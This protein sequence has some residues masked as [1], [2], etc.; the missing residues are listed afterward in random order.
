MITEQEV[1]QEKELTFRDYILKGKA[2]FREALRYWYIPVL[3]GLLGIAYQYYRYSKIVAKYPATITFIIDEDESGSS[4]LSGMLSQFGLSGV[5]PGRYNFDKILELSR[6]R[7]VIQEMMFNKISID[8]KED[9]IANHIIRLYEYFPETEEEKNELAGFYFSHDSLEAFSRTENKALLAIYHFIIGPPDNSNALVSADYN[10]DSNIMSLS[11][12]TIDETLS[13]EMAIRT[14][15][16][17]SDYYINK[18]IEKALH[19]FE[20][21][22]AKRDSILGVLRAT[23]YQLAN[24]RDRNRGLFLRSDQVPE[25]RLTRDLSAN[26]AMYA[27]VLKNTEMADF[28]LR[29]KTPF[30]Q[31]ID[32]PIPPIS[33]TQ[34]SLLRMLFIGA[35]LGGLIGLVIVSGRKFYRDVMTSY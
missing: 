35:F 24:F 28:S 3:L 21:V 23:E 13:L 7:R 20:I 11:A 6:S 25:Q 26:A 17:L 15:Q 29:T 32:A 31:V 9:F 27:E 16:S 14:F 4:G 33:P 1:V 34:V 2:Y 8:G 5:R 10:E 22:S 19:T 18:S 30:I 12:S